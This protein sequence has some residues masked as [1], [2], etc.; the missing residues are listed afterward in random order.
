MALLPLITLSLYS[1]YFER[2]TQLGQAAETRVYESSAASHPAERA[3]RR[4]CCRIIACSAKG[5]YLEFSITTH[6]W[7]GHARAVHLQ[8]TH[9]AVRLL[10]DESLLRTAPQ[11]NA[12]SYSWATSSQA[13]PLDR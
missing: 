6:A 8:T 11:P 12:T 10:R 1:I 13:S 3:R 2:A 9:L 5:R 4:H 7:I